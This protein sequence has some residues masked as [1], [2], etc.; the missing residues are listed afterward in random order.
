M[1]LVGA[2]GALLQ[3]MSC[4]GASFCLAVGAQTSSLQA[5]AVEWDGNEWHPLAVPAATVSLFSQVSCSSSSYCNGHRSTE[6]RLD[7]AGH[8]ER[9]VLVGLVTP[10][11]CDSLRCFLLHRNQLRRRR[12]G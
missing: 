2:V 8:L 12:P 10:A 1:Y 5:V 4:A 9:I 7:H 6:H 11:R 3:G